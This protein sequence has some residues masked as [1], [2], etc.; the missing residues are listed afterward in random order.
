MN[1]HR[2]LIAFLGVVLLCSG[3]KEDTLNPPVEKDKVA[4]GPVSN[5][6]VE[7]LPG[8]ARITYTLPKDKD[9]LYVKAE[10]EAKPGVLSESKGS[11][12][13]NS[14]LVEGF[15]DTGTYEVRLYA[16]DRSENRS[17]PV[18]VQVSPQ[19]PP[20][21]EVFN[22]LTVS[23]DFGGA[24]IQFENTH[25]ASIA[26]VVLTY[27]SLGSFV[28]VETFYT[29]LDKGSF[30]VR[31]FDTLER[32]FGI[33]VRDRWNNLTDTLH[34][35][36]SPLYET[37]LDKGGFSEVRLPTDEPSAWGWVMPNLWDGDAGT[38]FHTD[39]GGPS[40]Q[41]FTFDLGMEAKLSRFKILQRPD[42]WIFTHGNP[43]QFELW[44][45]T[46]PPSN[47]SWDNW[48]KLVE[49][50][51]VKPSGLPPGSNSQDDVDAA[52]RGEEFNVP[53]EAPSVRYI[54]FK[55]IRNWAGSGFVHFMEI[56]FWGSPVE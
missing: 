54:R 26:V 27:D 9:L 7:N 49:C 6:K 37:H 46:S 34:A 51:S 45:S 28:P 17:E 14:V 41:W 16:V 8:A 44:G 40:P 55:T 48:V 32:D 18:S 29:K 56:D 1:A 3:C 31:G 39:N 52:A 21:Q 2:I 24:N 47:G 15:G 53:I 35:V 33:Y 25:E 43:R 10:F 4:P 20:I 23:A 36:L 42:T 30:S 22:T 13:T 12:Y 38:G 19:T 50:E 5:L 11:L